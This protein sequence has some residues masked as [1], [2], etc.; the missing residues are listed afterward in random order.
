MST[1]TSAPPDGVG[2]NA[3]SFIWF[4]FVQAAV[5][6]AVN[7]ITGEYELYGWNAHGPKGGVSASRGCGG[8]SSGSDDVFRRQPDRRG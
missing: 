3:E 2:A 7:G 8:G 1:I 5:Y 4:A 6:N